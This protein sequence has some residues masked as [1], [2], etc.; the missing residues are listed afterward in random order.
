L[1]SS[2]GAM[3]RKEIVADELSL[4]RPACHSLVM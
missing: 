4:R 2:H 3:P 1:R